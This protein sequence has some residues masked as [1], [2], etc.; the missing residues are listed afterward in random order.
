MKTLIQ[1]IHC[2]PCVTTFTEDKPTFIEKGMMKMK[3]AGIVKE[4]M[5]HVWEK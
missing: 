2:L 3:Q 1:S 4:N 5:K